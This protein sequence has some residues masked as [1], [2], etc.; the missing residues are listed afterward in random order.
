M[1]TIRKLEKRDDRST[2]TCGDDDLNA[3]FRR[4]AGQH[5]FKRRAS[6]TYLAMDDQTFIAGFVTV[7]PGTL[8]RGDLGP[9]FKSYPPFPLPVL[10]L[11]RLGVSTAMQGQGVG[12]RLLRHGLTLAVKLM[13]SAGCVGVVVD[14]KANSLAFY[15]KYGFTPITMTPSGRHPRLFLP[16]T[17]IPGVAGSEP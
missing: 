2:F 10:L 3:F 9:A 15:E 13:D 14:A 1:T 6:V 7:S 12:G 8:T 11:A 16:I 5:Q 4:Q 17:A